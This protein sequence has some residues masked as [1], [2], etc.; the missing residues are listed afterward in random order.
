MSKKSIGQL[1]LIGITP[2]FLLIASPA[3]AA[4]PTAAVNDATATAPKEPDTTPKDPDAFEQGSGV[5]S[6]PTGPDTTPEMKQQQPHSIDQD[7]VTGSDKDTAT[8]STKEEALSPKKDST[9]DAALSKESTV[10]T[11]TETETKGDDAEKNAQAQKEAE[12]E[13]LDNEY[14]AAIDKCD[15]F[16]GNA[17]NECIAKVRTKYER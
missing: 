6:Q 1:I 12:A 17:K 9:T 11:K 5:K 10:P 3:T 4:D 13:K 2:L 14:K 16:S 7:S 8:G 15:E